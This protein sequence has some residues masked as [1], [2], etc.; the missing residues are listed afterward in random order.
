MFHS[1]NKTTQQA[2]DQMCMIPHNKTF[3]YEQCT[4][5]KHDIVH[6]DLINLIMSFLKEM[7]QG[8][9]LKILEE[10]FHSFES[11]GLKTKSFWFH[12]STICFW[13]TPITQKCRKKYIN[14]FYRKLVKL[15]LFC[16]NNFWIK[17][18][19]TI[20]NNFGKFE[21]SKNVNWNLFTQ[22]QGP[23]IS[24]GRMIHVSNKCKYTLK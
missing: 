22:Q 11:I 2:F 3:E 8:E 19:F 14:D 17:F 13:A 6:T 7:H 20:V 18:D 10:F 24:F 12:D 4:L 21:P 23:R 9:Y 15:L 1:K 5:Q 16:K